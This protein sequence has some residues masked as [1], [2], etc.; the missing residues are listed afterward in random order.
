MPRT[1]ALLAAAGA[2]LVARSA[3][4]AVGAWRATARV[5]REWEARGRPLQGFET[6]L[7]LFAID[8]PFPTV[9]VVGVARPALFISERVLRE[10]TTDEIEAM[11][12]H[13]T[14]HVTVR[15]NL[16]RFVIRACPDVLGR[17]SALDR[18]WSRAAEEAA[19][20]AA[21]AGRPATAV[22]LAQALIRVARLAPACNTPA[23]ASAFYLGGSIEARIRHLLAPTVATEAPT[24]LGCVLLGGGALAAA[25]LVIAGGPMIHQALEVLVRGLP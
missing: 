22:E 23:L 14:A 6:R 2:V 4:A 11:L 9:A 5:R 25:I 13:E 17:E 24:P 15:D 1:L 7:P 10:C 18:A 12:R 19:D 8:E 21:I 3:L 16:K 20:A